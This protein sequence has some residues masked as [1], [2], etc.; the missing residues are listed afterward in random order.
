MNEAIK[1]GLGALIIRII[2]LAENHKEIL[3]S[4][5][6]LASYHYYIGAKNKAIEIVKYLLKL[7]NEGAELPLEKAQEYK[8]MLQDMEDGIWSEKRRFSDREF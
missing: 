7:Y 1:K 2:T 6:Y 3:N 4:W 8:M 5:S